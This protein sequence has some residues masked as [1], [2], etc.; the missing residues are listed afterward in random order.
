VDVDFNYFQRKK[1]LGS[2]QIG[3][4]NTSLENIPGNV[5]FI[6]YEIQKIRRYANYTITANPAV[7]IG[8]GEVSSI[9]NCN[10]SLRELTI[11]FGGL[12]VG[13]FLPGQAENI[14]ISQDSLS[15]VPLEDKQFNGGL[16]RVGLFL[17]P[18]AQIDNIE[19]SV[20]VIN[21]IEVRIDPYPSITC[22]P[23]SFDPCQ[24][25]YVQWLTDNAFYRTAALAAANG[26]GG[27][28]VSFTFVCPADSTKTFLGYAEDLIMN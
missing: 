24:A 17:L 7:P 18:G 6:N 27:P 2:Y 13:D 28:I 22:N 11:G 10:F 16:N 14:F 12:V 5:G 4:T 23:P 21:G 8:V 26:T 9:S 3:D 15:R 20:T 25:L 1:Y 19:Y